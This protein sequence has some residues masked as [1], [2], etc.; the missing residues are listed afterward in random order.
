MTYVH[1][2]QWSRTRV[3]R[4]GQRWAG[5]WRA[6][7]RGTVGSVMVDTGLTYATPRAAA[8]ALTRLVHRFGV[9]P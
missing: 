7:R 5:V 1:D 6:W 4:Q 9:A 3:E 2:D 8:E